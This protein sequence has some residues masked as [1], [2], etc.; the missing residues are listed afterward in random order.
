FVDKA[1]DPENEFLCDGITESVI[2]SLS[3]LPE[4]RVIA[5]STAFTYKGRSVDPRAIGRELRV[6][7][8]L[9]GQVSRAADNFRLQAELIRVSDAT[10]LWSERYERPAAELSELQ[11]QLS[12]DIAAKLRARLSDEQQQRVARVYTQSQAAYQHYLRGRFY[13]EKRT[14]SDLRRSVVEFERAIASDPTYALAYAGLADTYRLFSDYDI[15]APTE[16]CP[17]AKAAA[18]KALELDSDLA[19]ARA[20]LAVLLAHY[21]WNLPAAEQEFQRA[22]ALNANY[23]AAHHWYGFWYLAVVGRHEEAI[24]ALKRAQDLDPLSPIIST[25][26]G[27]VLGDAGRFDEAVAQL[28]RTIALHPRFANAHW[29]L[30][31]VFLRNGRF[32]DA[33]RE[34][35]EGSR[36]APDEAGHQIGIAIAQAYAGRTDEARTALEQLL[37]SPTGHVPPYWLAMV[38]AALGETERA[39]ESLEQAYRERAAEMPRLA[40]EPLFLKL[41]SAERF[42]H[43]V[44]RVRLPQ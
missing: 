26:L 9:L 39:L 16:S 25:N 17:K 23:A 42:R 43:L 36:L 31:F 5:R 8:V 21:D 38:Y 33:L 35:Q 19:E 44:S 41:R 40:G 32:A 30:G 15:V 22:L 12:A 20:S 18:N 14:Q 34:F 1:N 37:Q 3:R 13:Q 24:A 28:R 29:K 7:A 27:A 11:P 2:N 6:D 4:L 10:Q